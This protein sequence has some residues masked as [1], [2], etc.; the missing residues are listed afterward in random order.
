MSD[1]VDTG[2]A[3]GAPHRAPPRRPPVLQRAGHPARRRVIAPG[4]RRS[5][6]ACAALALAVTLC[7]RCAPSEVEAEAALDASDAPSGVDVAAAVDGVGVADMATRACSDPHEPNDWLVTATPLPVEPLAAVLCA[8]DVDLYAVPPGASGMVSARL[9]P[10][11]AADGL[12]LSLVAAA[13]L[14]APSLDILAEGAWAG[15][16]LAVTADV[17]ADHLAFVRVDGAASGLAYRLEAHVEAGACVDDPYEP[18]DTP[19]DA[20]AVSPHAVVAA[21]VCPADQDYWVVDVPAHTHLRLTA[22]PQQALGPLDLAGW[23][24]DDP[25][26]A[27]DGA[28]GPALAVPAAVAPR[29]LL[30]R[31]SAPPGGSA[32]RY[33]LLAETWDA[34]P[35]VSGTVVGTVRFEDLLPSRNGY[36][37]GTWLP[38][39]HIRVE[40]VR[41]FDEAVAAAGVTD[42]EGRFSLDLTL[43]VPPE[44]RIRA[45]TEAAPPA[46]AVALRLT[47]DPESPPIAVASAPFQLGADGASVDVLATHDGVGGAFNAL[48]VAL[49][50]LTLV[51][52]SLGAPADALALAWTPGGADLCGTCYLGDLGVLALSGTIADDDSYDDAVIAHEVGHHFELHHGVADSPGG[53]HDGR[54]TDPRL[55]WSEGFAN[56]FAAVVL[57]DPMYVD[58]AALGA[59]LVID[60]ESVSHEHS[61][62]TSDG[63]VNGAVSEDLVAAVLWDLYDAGP[64]PQDP[65]SSPPDALLRTSIEWFHGPVDRGPAGVDLTDHLDGLLCHGATPKA[66]VDTVAVQQRKF[67]HDL[68]PGADPGAECD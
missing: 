37:P 59:T 3:G 49:R 65:A 13:N 9:L 31:V 57:D 38:A 66:W 58:V 16:T 15:A 55:A 34:A 2:G 36:A 41:G 30:A 63:T 67:P 44:V 64:E 22:A 24:G 19:D 61:Y 39:R 20:V 11:G 12:R 51:E 47:A 33:T 7:A 27:Q 26:G 53:Y 43:D 40:A 42:A 35:P 29:T 46:P 4:A 45:V 18:N 14:S 10:G 68:D 6:A 48:D 60:L 50:A 56:A 54:R 25:V 28:A 52:E 17:E 1:G 5:T 62:G 32:V 21:G 8:G 23:L